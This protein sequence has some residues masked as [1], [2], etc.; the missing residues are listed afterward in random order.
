MPAA[1]HFY[2]ATDAMIRP[3]KELLFPS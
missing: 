1:L 2:V 3:T